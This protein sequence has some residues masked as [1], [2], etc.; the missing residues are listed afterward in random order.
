MDVE[1]R[2]LGSG[3]IALRHE[4]VTAMRS[5][6][7]GGRVEARLAPY[8]SDVH[9]AWLSEDKPAAWREVHASLLF[10][11]IAG[12]TPLTERLARHG[13]A[14]V[15]QLVDAL[16]SVIGP[17]VRLA[18]ALGGDTLKFGGDALLVLFAGDGHERRACAAAYEMQCALRPFRR[19]RTSA[20]IVS[21]RAS[22]AVAS[23]VVQLF[24]V[25][26]LFREV[27]VAGPVSS[28][29]LRLE[30]R[31]RAGEA[32]L[33][34]ATLEA[35][36]EVDRPTP[37]RDGFVALR[38]RPAVGDLPQDADRVGGDPARGLPD[39]LHDHLGADA[40][41]E[42][43]LVTVG[44][45]QFRGVDD[46]LR[47]AGP[48]TTADE[49]DALMVRVQHA[50]HDHGVTPLCTDADRDGGKLLLVAGAPAAS[51]DDEDRMLLAMRS[52][53][54]HD[55]ELRIRA[56][57]HRGRVFVVHLGAAHRRTYTT[58]G[59]TTNL[60]AR[61]MGNAP[62]GRVLATRAVLD[63]ARAPH[64]LAP[65]A[66]FAVKGKRG[67]VDADLVGAPRIVARCRVIDGALF[68]RAAELRALRDAVAS[69]RCGEGRIVELIAETG[70]GKS[71]LLG[72]LL[73]DEA[74]VGGLRQVVVEAD[75]YG[76]SSPYHAVSSPL[77]ALM[78]PECASD[79]EV[80]ATLALHVE[81][82]MPEARPLLPL[83]ALP[84][85][86][87]LPATEESARLSS[88]VCRT[89]LHTLLDRLLRQLLAERA[90]LF[91]IDDAQWLDDASSDLLRAI[92][93]RAKQRGWTAIV[94]RRPGAGGL[95]DVPD[96]DSRLR[97]APL[98]LGVSRLLV[99]AQDGKGLAPHA[100]AALVAR[101]GGNPLF[102]RELL[103]CSGDPDDLPET[104]EALLDERIDT[105]APGDRLLLRRAAVL[106]DRFPMSWLGQ[107]LAIERPAVG[108]A[109]LPLGAFLEVDADE[110]RFKHTLHREAAY[111][112]LPCSTRR[113]LHAHAAE[114]IER[115]R[116]E[117]A[118]DILSLHFLR[119][120]RCAQAWR[121]GRVAAEQAR[122]RHAHADAAALYARALDAARRLGARDPQ[123]RGAALADR[124]VPAHEL[125][126]V[127]ESLG[128]AH[129]RAGELGRANEA[130]TRAR[131]HADGDPLRNGHLMHCH[132]SVAM[133]GGEVRRAARWLLRG[134]RILA[135]H[136]S[137]TARSCRATI[138]A[139]L[140]DVRVS[141]GRAGEAIVL[142]AAAIDESEAV[143]AQDALAHACYVLDR[144]L[145]D[146]GR[147]GEAVHSARALEIYRRL[148]ELECE[149]VVLG[150]LGSFAYRD[151]RWGD[152][153]ELYEAGRRASTQA[154]NLGRAA[155]V[156]CD[157]AEVR[158]NQGR[159]DDARRELGRA[160]EVWR[161][162]GYAGGVAQALALLGRVE[163]RAGAFDTARSHLA[164]ALAGFRGLHVDP[165]VL[166]T[167]ALV[168]E[169]CVLEGHAHEAL[170]D[171]SRLIAAPG[172]A[173]HAPLLHRVCGVAAAQ[174]GRSESAR[175]SLAA[176]V[177]AARERRDDFELLL[178]LDALAAVD[179]SVD[180]ALRRERDAI[181]TRLDIWR[182]PAVTP[183]TLAVT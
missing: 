173:R 177:A 11:D 106:G 1:L 15:E 19:M 8:L 78:T 32:L 53:V 166:W 160:L 121:Y 38:T 75:A 49:L 145:V 97:L 81:R 16:G 155:F 148:G 108:Q 116:G 14:G 80:E 76:A 63:R 147:A 143:G 31:A 89:Q 120:H 69:G 171:A 83:L 88:A 86:L 118:A 150:N 100:V 56:G 2:D 22:A 113:A 175:A 21:L 82:H 135:T 123:G 77:R 24:L 54:A 99:A 73:T 13:K 36:A 20:G 115:E 6:A 139:E 131:L 71:R 127:Y 23:G 92:L 146:A 179:G 62:D 154:G 46:L 27:V 3:S 112:A 33:G 161:G 104:L 39:V 91:V 182:A 180:D 17:L 132:A 95:D 25:G 30:R 79:A 37:R 66:P 26:D 55:G 151:G 29:V 4:A 156:T 134:L 125:S 174:L 96:V 68:G 170:R 149:A 10:I 141:Q 101:S 65:V 153:V 144:A 42:H 169:A 157:I 111:A 119:A 163:A 47:R 162:T 167:Q 44:F 137:T 114:I 34:Q 152:A 48:Q 168:T 122:A 84:L 60:A 105:L 129:A 172:T 74:T 43:R 28:E 181:A 72:E 70:M 136:D 140:A 93:R 176:S 124:R 59:D 128:E 126:E 67:L 117:E 98:D 142:C 165:E 110:V 57:V 9:R 107:M 12:F 85:G 102:L 40:E 50:C 158:C 41:S 164:A 61:V 58:M 159:A 64:A 35:L 51:T 18:R 178:A 7:D 45:A 130:L 5:T 183:A 109:L 90:A 52:I 138:V 87:D 94:S 103:R 133:D